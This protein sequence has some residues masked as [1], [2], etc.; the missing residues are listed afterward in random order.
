MRRQMNRFSS[1]LI[2]ALAAI[3]CAAPAAADATGVLDRAKSTGKLTFGYRTG[4]RP[5]SYTGAMGAPDG[6]S[7]VL[8]KQIADEVKA[9]VDRQDLTVEWVAVTLDQRFDDLKQGKVDLLCGADS[10]TLARRREVAFSL[11]IF[12]GGIGALVRTDAPQQLRQVLEGEVDR[13]KP[14]WRGTMQQG[15]DKRTFSAVEVPLRQ[16]WLTERIGEFRLTATAVPVAS[17]ELGVQR[18]VDR[19]S[20]VLFGDRAILLDVAKHSAPGA[21]TVVLN[22]QFTYEPLALAMAQCDEAFRFIVDRTLS[23]AYRSPD[24]GKLYADTFGT[25]D[26]TTLD[27]FKIIALPD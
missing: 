20:D 11:P 3:A 13:T 2:V 5:F 1:T 4:A 18:V 7:V 23:R 19:K 14:L 9:A 12:P 15:L 8:C 16:R 26:Q 22:R 25:P 24:F 21:N 10:E 17:Y 6:F 27:F